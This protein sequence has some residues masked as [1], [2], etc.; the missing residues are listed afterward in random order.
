MAEKFDNLK[1]RSRY[2]R[3]LLYP[4]CAEHAAAIEVIKNGY[5]DE[6]IGITHLA[7]DGEKEHQHFV[8]LFDNPRKTETVCEK[9]GLVSP[10]GLADDQ[11]VRAIVK[12]QKRKVDQQLKDCCV[13]LTHRNAPEK[14]Q[15]EVSQ[16]FGDQARIK[17]T[18]KQVLKYES[19]EIDMPDCV[20]GILDW[21]A[22]QDDIIKVYSFGRWLANSPYF[23]ANN[24]RIVWAAI[25]E[26]NLR[27]WNEQN[28]RP[29]HFDTVD[30]QY[31]ESFRELSHDEE[32]FLFR[33]GFMFSD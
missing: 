23:K 25:K 21:I 30:P 20:L 22:S 1:A 27:V 18:A 2:F 33:Q 3:V 17:W 15:Y 16:L 19:Q 10:L 24:N 29:D 31:D 32:D 6:Y 7:Q 12:K 14:E 11:F 26:H 28:P 4:D 9:L 8:L 5:P 13:Y